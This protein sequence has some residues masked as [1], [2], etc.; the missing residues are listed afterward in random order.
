MQ[1]YGVLPSAPT[2]FRV[3]NIDVDFAI[4][5]WEKPKFLGESVT[6]YNVH[7]RALQSPDYRIVYEVIH[8]SS[9]L[10]VLIC[11]FIFSKVMFTLYLIF[12]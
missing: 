6:H 2:K 12:R 1:G 11:L 7:M 3:T 9:Q 4:L 8:M 10:C 5:N